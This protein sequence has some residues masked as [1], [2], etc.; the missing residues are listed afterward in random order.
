M[1]TITFYNT[2][3]VL[4]YRILVKKRGA[5]PASSPTRLAGP[6]ATLGHIILI[7]SLYV[8]CL[9]EK[10]LIILQV[11]CL[12]RPVLEPMIYHIRGE[13]AAWLYS[14]SF[15]SLSQKCSSII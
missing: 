10:Q 13:H 11:F 12:I 14:K 15:T 8:V 5:C 6:D 1:A 7:Q 9:V 4:S 3:A 2:N